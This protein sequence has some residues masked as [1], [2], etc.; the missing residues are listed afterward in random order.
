MATARACEELQLIAECEKLIFAI[1]QIVA[2]WESGNLAASVN[3]ARICADE[4]ED[5]IVNHCDDN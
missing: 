4:V 1:R 5:F 2:S 3:E